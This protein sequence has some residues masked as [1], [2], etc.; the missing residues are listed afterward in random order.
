M[1]AT[2]A[3]ME[4]PALEHRWAVVPPGSRVHVRKLRPDGT[5]KLT[6]DGRVLHADPTGVVVRAAFTAPQV[7]LGC[8]TFRDGDIFIEFYRW[9]CWYTVA[10]VLAADGSCTGWYGDVCMPP[11]WTA[12]G[13]LSY[14]D[15]DLDLWAGA[16]G[17]VVLLDEDEFAAR[18][19]AGVFTAAQLA[20]AAQGWAALRALAAQGQL[21]HW[22]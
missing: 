16:D 1:D 9:A 21:P 4:T 18:R 14:V 22:P 5:A 13:V 11:R 7:D 20:G 15:L 10:Q 19:A 6:W 17:T 12:P 2:A 8:V 3:G